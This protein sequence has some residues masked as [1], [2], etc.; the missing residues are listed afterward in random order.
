MSTYLARLDTSFLE[1]SRHQSLPTRRR[2]LK[3]D[4]V[5]RIVLPFLEFFQLQWLLHQ[6]CPSFWPLD[7]D[8]DIA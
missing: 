2:W 8:F 5:A 1:L 3:D 7:I 6:A 4:D